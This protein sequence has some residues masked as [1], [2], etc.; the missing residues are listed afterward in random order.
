MNAITKSSLETLLQNPVHFVKSSHV[1][2]KAVIH[3]PSQRPL[4]AQ[5]NSKS[6]ST[7]LGDELEEPKVVLSPANAVVSQWT[8]VMNHP[9]G[10]VNQGNTCFL[11]S[12]MQ[13]LMHVP[14]LV[15]YLL[16]DRHS[17]SCRMNGC[18]FC[19][20]QEHANKAYPGKG[21]KKGQPFSP[22]VARSLKREWHLQGVA[23]VDTTWTDAS[24]H[25]QAIQNR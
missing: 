22:N 15:E 20:V 23:S 24:R 12:V 18:V 16:S 13:S 7:T 3:N 25:W 14:S 1:Y 17:E 9:P 4:P 5:A 10:L 2:G 21:Q 11:N 8:R 19:L 6:P